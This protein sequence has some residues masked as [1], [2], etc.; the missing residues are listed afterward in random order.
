MKSYLTWH[1][2]DHWAWLLMIIACS[3]AAG[4]LVILLYRYE[5]KLISR[6]LGWTLL[7]LRLSVIGFVFLALLEPVQ[8]TEIDKERTGRILLAVDVSESMDTIDQQATDAEKL[9][10]ARALGMIGHAHNAER[11]DQW[12]AALDAGQEPVWATAEEFPDPQRRARQAAARKQNLYE[13]VFPEL[14]KLSRRE[15]VSRLLK[16][17]PESL[18]EQLDQL[19][20]LETTLFAGEV[21]SVL[22]EDLSERLTGDV[23]S[24][25][26]EMTNLSRPAEWTPS[27]PKAPPLAAVILFTDGRHNSTQSRQPWSAFSV[28][29]YPVMIGSKELPKDLAFASIDYPREPVSQNDTSVIRAQ[30]RTAGYEG[31]ELT[32]TLGPQDPQQG[33]VQT[34]T[35]LVTGPISEVQF[36]LETSKLGRFDYR[37]AT[38]VLPGE[39]RQDNNERSLT[40]TVVDDTSDVLLLDGEGR[41][42]FRFLHNALTRDEQVEVQ[43]ILFR[44]PYMGLLRDTFF[45]RQLAIPADLDDQS[46]SPFANLDVVMIGDIAPHH[47][48]QNTWKWLDHYVREEGGTIVFIA[49]KHSMPLDYG[50]H[51]IVNKLLPIER[52]HTINLRTPDQKVSPSRRGFHLTLTPD[53]EQETFLQFD[54]DPEENRRIW[55]NLPGHTWGMIGDAKGEATV[56][57]AVIPPGET[58]S[59]RQERHNA[60]I[61][62]QQVGFGQVLWI[63]IDSTW[64]W[65]YRK[66]DEYHHR[67]WGQIVRWA[68]RF[69]AVAKNEYV[70][71]GPMQPS[72][73][74]GEEVVFRALWS[75]QFLKKF[76]NLK[77]RAVLYKPGDPKQTPLATIAL[78]PSAASPLDYEGRTSSLRPGEY[79]AE[80]QVENADLG[81]NKVTAEL[82]IMEAT[83]SELSEISANQKLLESLAKAT[84][85]RFFL[86]DQLDELPDL[87]TDLSESTSL[88][89]ERSLWDSWP[90][91]LLL[92]ALLTTEWVLRKINGLP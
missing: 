70:A 35:F 88:R 56:L 5:R 25:L 53:G 39:T 13:T 49:G 89:T 32:I 79:R 87:F 90:L 46:A 10:L 85:G 24:L 31:Q 61:V 83:T 65:R 4:L 27:S 33:E 23:D 59:L 54:T 42:E 48:P 20:Q 7:T 14:D 71:F 62:Q 6:S 16:N 22:P 1:G 66:G 34:K 58:A 30:L 55:S 77:A 37:L 45:P 69:K 17:H 47:V 18:V 60:L 84:G 67:F 80:L 63:G 82:Q 19:G 64:R 75:R 11:L 92:F 28:P 8:I 74:L 73:E 3:L 40:V 72:V 76:P 43:S 44:Q 91:L 52:P 29:V 26:P 86:P 51:P 9:R 78:N 2:T 15:I 41:W 68:A 21:E 57:A 12:Q 81:P 38:K 50:G 36:Q